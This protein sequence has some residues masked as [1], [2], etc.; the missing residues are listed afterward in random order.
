MDQNNRAKICDFGFAR[1]N[2]KREARAMTLCGTDDWMAPEVIMGMDYNEKADVF[3]YGIVLLEIITRQKV[4][5]SL[6]RSA[7][8]GFELDVNKTKGIIPE[9]C[10]SAFS[11]IAFAVCK[12]SPEDR[13]TFKDVVTQL[14]AAVKEFPAAVAPTRGG[15]GGR[16]AFR[17]VRGRGGPPRGGPGGALRGGPGG[18][19]RGSPVRGRGAP[20]TV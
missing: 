18:A 4:S 12:Y 11:D 19:S 8:D 16:G 17:G 6:Q 1:L 20:P 3:S 5:T 13:P 14:T 10:P 2:D 7:M 15:R 9:D